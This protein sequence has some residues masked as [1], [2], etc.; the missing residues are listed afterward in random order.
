VAIQPPPAPVAQPS[1]PAAPPAKKSGCA[2]CS[3]GCLGCLGVVALVVA[4]L[5]GGGYFFL[6]AQAQGGVASPAALLVVTNP[7]EVGQNDT[8]YSPATSGQSLGAGAS[9]RTGAGGH[10]VIQFPD[11]SLMRLSPSTTVTVQAA[12]LSNGGNLK[13]ATLIQ[14]IGRTLTTV[15]HLA[16][17][18]S[19]QVGGHSVTATV[20]GT[21]F[22]VLV[23]PDG[24][25]Q[26]KVF[27]GVV[28]VA[29]QTAVDLAAGQELDADSSGRLS[30]PRAIGSDLTDPYPLQDQCDRSAMAGSDPGT[31]QTTVAEN[32]QPGQA[33]PVNYYSAGG[34]VTVALC[35]PGSL[36]RL[37]VTDPH[38][39]VHAAQGAS[40]VLIKIASGPSGLYVATVR[41]LSVPTTGEP[42]AVTFATSSGCVAR[43]VDDG[44]VVREAFSPDQLTQMLAQAGLTGISVQ[45]QGTSE[46]SARIEYQSNYVGNAIFVTV[47]FY[48]ATPNL[49]WVLTQVS[50]RGL[51][52]TTQVVSRLTEADKSIATIPTDF[53]VDRV[54]S[55]AG[56]DGHLMVIEG[57]RP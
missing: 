3:F 37:S 25:N 9:V 13:S 41:A 51:N 1:T 43:N 55:C 27:A 14:K 45:V 19:F 18:A 32:L 57:H 50:F 17:G 34:V 20:R 42:F 7:V 21:Q 44:L 49:G 39:L 53:S 47:D 11:G 54:Y 12:R 46:T 5:V 4:L 40:P 29:G 2:G 31:A 8:S 38:G 35:Y 23:R 48:A 33:A 24:S 10:A 28:H 56:P 30:N 36:M 15:Q 22:E 6:V 52:I 16:G 26:I